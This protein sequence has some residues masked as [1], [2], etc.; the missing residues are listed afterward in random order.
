MLLRE[1]GG[2]VEKTA[3]Y[4]EWPLTRVQAAANYA[5]A[6]PDEIAEALADNDSYDEHKVRALLPQTH[7]SYFDEQGRLVEQA[8]DAAPAP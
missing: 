5:A 3:D 2:T 6:F 1:H 4:L 8:A 7:V